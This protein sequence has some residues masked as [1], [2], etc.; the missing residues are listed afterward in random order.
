MIVLALASG[1]TRLTNLHHR[2]PGTSAGGLERHVRQMV[3][4][5]LVTRT[6]FKEMPPRVELELTDAGRELIPVAG[7]LARWGMRNA[8][9]APGEREQVEIAVLLWTLP[10][11]LEEQATLRDGRLEAL[12]AG[13]D[14]PVRRL[15]EIRRGRL[16]PAEQAAG[17]SEQATVRIEGDEQAWIAAFGPCADHS[18]LRLTGD[19]QL[20]KEVIAALPRP[21]A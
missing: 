16:G 20:A 5:G 10:A 1:R 14:P 9:T 13:T 19:R 17:A 11:L 7:A 8:W 6:R 2:L 3:A 18:R 21:D 15:Y 12:V 4:L